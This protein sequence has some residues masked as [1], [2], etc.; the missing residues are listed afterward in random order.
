[1]KND[2]LFFQGFGKLI[3]IKT[4]NK[5]N[6]STVEKY[7]RHWAKFAKKLCKSFA[8]NKKMKNVKTLVF[9]CAWNSYALTLAHSVANLV[10]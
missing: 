8:K 1:M 10:E 4:S 9:G 7:V 6:Q 3:D 2:L 5:S